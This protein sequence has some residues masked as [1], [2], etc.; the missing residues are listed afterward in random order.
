M[1]GGGDRTRPRHVGQWRP[2]A[3]ASCLAVVPNTGGWVM[4]LSYFGGG[5]R[6]RPRHVGQA[7]AAA[8]CQAVAVAGGRAMPDSGGRARPHHVGLP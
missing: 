2:N 8:S 5:D 3:A 7:V 6:T 1:S 4:N